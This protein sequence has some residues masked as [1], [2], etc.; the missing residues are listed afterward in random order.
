MTDGEEKDD[1]TPSD[2][3]RLTK[4]ARRAGTR[5]NVIHFCFE[6]RPN[7]SLTSLAKRTQGQFKSIHIRSLIDPDWR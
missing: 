1:P 7:S 5:I 4:L 3:R 2:L 6:E